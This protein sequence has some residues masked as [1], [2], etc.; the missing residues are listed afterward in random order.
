MRSLPD[1]RLGDR[2][3]RLPLSSR[4]A[5]DLAQ[6]WLSTEG[7]ER[8]RLARRLF[9]QEPGWALWC[10]AL[11]DAPQ[12]PSNDEL[13]SQWATSSALRERVFRLFAPSSAGE[14]VANVE[15][16]KRRSVAF[17]TRADWIDQAS[18]GDLS[19]VCE[20]DAA[21]GEGSDNADWNLA[22]LAQCLL[23]ESAAEAA[24]DE[25]ERRVEQEKLLALRE[26]A[27]GASHEIN[28]PLANIATRA[29]GLMRDETDVERRR[30]L[31]VIAAQAL[32]AH[33]MIADIMLF[34][35]PPA[36][37]KVPTSLDAV[38][39]RVIAEL[40]EWSALQGTTIV[41]RSPPADWQV[42]VD[43]TQLAVALKAILDNALEALQRGGRIEVTVARPTSKEATI[44][45]RDTGPG[46]S[47]EV[48]RHL[49][50]PYYSGR[51]AGRGLGIGLCKAWRIVVDH[52]GS[53]TVENSPDGGAQFVITLPLADFGSLSQNGTSN[54]KFFPD[55]ADSS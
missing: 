17:D 11:I 44:A 1:F 15:G 30:T 47:D 21:N 12:R 50:D 40:A 22:R 33:S 34:A 18:S 9:D 4:G 13:A 41:R 6:L 48:R 46:I 5:V 39:D 24:C 38:V 55:V 25:R 19:L 27:Y 7:G 26:F 49:F 37:R 54:C 42:D 3:V 28:N 31:A 8:L 14:N 2:I 36:L 43:A 52:H 16:G 29:Q 53:L 20:A 45:I 23:A 10:A 51:E 35:K 32:R